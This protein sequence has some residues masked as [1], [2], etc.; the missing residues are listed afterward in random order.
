ME[1]C[2]HSGARLS[3]SAMSQAVWGTL[4]NAP[5]NGN[6]D[7][8]VR[9]FR[10]C[11]NPHIASRMQTS[12]RRLGSIFFMQRDSVVCGPGG[13]WLSLGHYHCCIAYNFNLET[14]NTS[15]T[16]ISIF[17]GT[18]SRS[19]VGFSLQAIPVLKFG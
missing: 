18:L 10:C 11:H 6:R 1:T 13:L 12:V 4:R 9:A 14:T 8:Y 15:E 19:I 3:A 2:Q 16:E 7:F 5:I 17:P